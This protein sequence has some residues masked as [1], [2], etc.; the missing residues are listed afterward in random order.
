[1]TDHSAVQ[2]ILGCQSKLCAIG[3]ASLTQ[4]LDKEKVAFELRGIVPAVWCL[5]DY[6]SLSGQITGTVS[7]MTALIS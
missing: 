7:F 4:C 2:I 3:V 5:Q 1:M 6:K